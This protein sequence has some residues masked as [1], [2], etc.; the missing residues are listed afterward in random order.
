MNPSE[1]ELKGVVHNIKE[2]I[3]HPIRHEAENVKKQKHSEEEEGKR[4]QT[5]GSDLGPTTG[6]A[7]GTDV[8]REQHFNK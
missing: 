3:P 7:P 5:L 8:P 4:G 1:E 6:Y 2:K